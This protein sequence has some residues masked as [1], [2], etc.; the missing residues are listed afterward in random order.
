MKA[1]IVFTG[2]SDYQNHCV[3]AE[4]M[5][6]AERIFVAKYWPT[7]IKSIVL[8]SEYVQ[9]QKWDEQPKEN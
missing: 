7:T 9:I 4:N 6:E 8:Y 3:I 2:F 1:F 5:A